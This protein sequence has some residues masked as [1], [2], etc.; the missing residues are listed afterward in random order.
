MAER[1]HT[2]GLMNFNY[3]KDLNLKLGKDRKKKLE[4]GYEQYHE[5]KLKEEKRKRL[6]ILAFILLVLLFLG[7]LIWMQMR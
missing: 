5:R 6:I 2:G 4:E 3:N 7:I 1:A